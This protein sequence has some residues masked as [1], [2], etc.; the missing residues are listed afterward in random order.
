MKRTNRSKKNEWT[1]IYSNQDMKN[2]Q[3]INVWIDGGDNNSKSLGK[4]HPFLTHKIHKKIGIRKCG[5]LKAHIQTL[6]SNW[7]KR[8][9]INDQYLHSME[10]NTIYIHKYMCLILFYFHFFFVF[11]L[12]FCFFCFILVHTLNINKWAP[13]RIPNEMDTLSSNDIYK[14]S[15]KKWFSQLRIFEPMSMR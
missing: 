7:L 13:L 12:F 4:G 5:P 14:L 3:I 10:K 6:I 8:I 11:F 1:L 2:S 15:P 9:A